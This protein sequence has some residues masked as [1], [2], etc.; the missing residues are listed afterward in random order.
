MFGTFSPLLAL[1]AASLCPVPAQAVGPLVDVGYARYQGSAGENGITQ[2]LGIRY[3]A[4]PLGRLRYA[5]PADPPFNRTIQNA[6]QHGPLCLSTGAH[7]PQSGHSEDCLFLDV[8]APTHARVGSKLP[9]VLQ[10]PG[11]GLNLLSEANLNGSELIQAA[12]MNAVVVTHNYRVGTFGFLPGKEV[13]ARGALNAGFLDQRKAMQWVQEH[14]ASFGGD[15][16]HVVL[17]G[18]S[19]GAQSI[20]VHLTAYGGRPTNLFRAV[21]AESQAF[22]A[23]FDISGSQYI[24]DAFVER[25]GCTGAVDTLTCLRGLDIA[26]LQK[27]SVVMPLPGRT[28][29]PNYLY[30]ATV[31]GDLIPDFPYT[32]WKEGRILDVPAI[33][34]ADTNDGTKFTP[35]NVS[36]VED[37]DN[38]LL[39]NWNLI[40]QTSLDTINKYYP[41]LDQFPNHGEYFLSAATAYGELRYA[42]FGIFVSK[43]CREHNNPRSTWLYRY[44]VQDPAQI[45]SGLGTPHTVEVVAIWGTNSGATVPA[46]YLTTNKN[47]IPIMQGYWT[48]FIR[49]LNPNT[50]RAPGAPEWEAFNGNNRILLETNTTRMETISPEQQEH[51]D[52]FWQIGRAIGQ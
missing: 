46:S 21:A 45:A 23:L 41:V 43:Y 8:Y 22:P 42:C 48:S 24:Y 27:A 26:V 10:I 52:F 50:F 20:T 14:I 4:P 12:G 15:P 2:W 1:L 31:D 16:G 44:N 6:T 33:F 38:F 28:N 18:A 49:T 32:L 25:T 35:A 11:G 39:D 37:M 17:S 47:I 51:C 13:H 34:G 3:A 7:Y 19:A 36:T 5:A 9:V 29:P 40:N 30:G